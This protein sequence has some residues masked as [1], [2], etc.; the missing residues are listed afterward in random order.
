MS[1]AAIESMLEAFGTPKRQHFLGVIRYFSKNLYLLIR[2]FFPLLAGFALSD[3]IRNYGE[4][5]AVAVF[6]FVIIAALVEY[7]R[8]RFH[9]D[10][11]SMT[12]QKGLLE[13][14]TINIPF[15]RIQALH[16]EQAPWQR[17]IGLTGL[18]IDTAGTSGSEVDLQALKLAEAKLLRDGIMAARSA[19]VSEIEVEEEPSNALVHLTLK[20]LLKV[21][22]TQNHLR[23]GFITFGAIIALYEPFQSWI[24]AWLASLPDVVWMVLKWSWFLFIPVFVL[25]LSGAV[26]KYYQLQA[27]L[28]HQEVSLRGGLLKRFEYRIPLS[29][30]QILEWRSN[31]ARRLLGI[32][33]LRI[34]Q[35]SAQ[36]SNQ[37]GKD[38]SMAIPGISETASNGLIAEIFQS[39]IVYPSKINLKPSRFLFYRILVL[40][41]LTT[42]ALTFTVDSYFGKTL[43]IAVALPWALV[44]ARKVYENHWISMTP[45]VCMIHS[46]WLRKKRSMFTFHQLQRVVFNQNAIMRKRGVAHI[47][48][49]TAAGNRTFRYLNEAEARQLYD[50]SLASIEESESD[51]M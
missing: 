32:E 12:I 14:E 25:S 7:W 36:E 31:I 21:G 39:W 9:V 10:D 6:A 29:K 3:E 13:R 34:F 30:V 26:V 35:A 22:L 45:D 24:D 47:T 5:I 28:N 23:N 33:T 18:K 20:E 27:N 51:W 17:F 49:A 37:S 8:F 43:I 50:W 42:A 1:M 48:L 44:S 19:N 2:S 16:M 46:G 40:R 11:K 41:I 38:L 15:E 4:F